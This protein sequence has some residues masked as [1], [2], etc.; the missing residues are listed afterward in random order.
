MASR[1]MVTCSP[2]ATS[3]SNSRSLGKSHIS[4][5]SDTSLLVSPDMAET[6]TTTSLPSS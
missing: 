1:E 2:V 6:T 3:T 5:A 4:L